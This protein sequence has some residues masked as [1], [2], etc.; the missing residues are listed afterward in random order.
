MKNAPEC[1]Y[2]CQEREENG[3]EDTIFILAGN[4]TLAALKLIW[5][6]D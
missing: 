5:G 4:V 3:G 2:N 6:R 1:R